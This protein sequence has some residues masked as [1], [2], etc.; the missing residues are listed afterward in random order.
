MPPLFSLPS[1]HFL[2][3][4]TSIHVRVQIFA[5]SLA[6]IVY[7]FVFLGFQQ[8]NM[9]HIVFFLQSFSFPSFHIHIF[10]ILSCNLN[11]ICNMHFVFLTNSQSFMSVK[12]TPLPSNVC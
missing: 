3:I 1:H 4:S 8:S 10:V 9:S 5:L 7:L 2:P 12:N 6:F 11:Q